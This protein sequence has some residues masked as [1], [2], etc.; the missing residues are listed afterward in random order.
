MYVDNKRFHNKS[1]QIERLI[2]LL[3]KKNM[4]VMMADDIDIHPL[5]AISYCLFQLAD[6]CN[7]RYNKVSSEI[8]QVFDEVCCVIGNKKLTEPF[9]F[10]AYPEENK[11]IKGNNNADYIDNLTVFLIVKYNQIMKKHR[12]YTYMFIPTIRKRNINNKKTEV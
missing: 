1:Y 10:E 7:K 9:S 3:T 6:N 11:I 2:Q 5:V 8:W 12:N 4:K